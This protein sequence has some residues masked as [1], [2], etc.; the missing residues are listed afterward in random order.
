MI[1]KFDLNDDQLH[2]L[3][4]YADNTRDKLII[5]E[6]YKMYPSTLIIET[7]NC[8][9]QLFRRLESISDENKCSELQYIEENY[10]VLTEYVNETT[11]NIISD[12]FMDVDFDMVESNL[13]TFDNLN[14]VCVTPFNYLELKGKVP[15]LDYRVLCQILVAD[16]KKLK[17]SDIHITCGYKNMEP[18][19]WVD[20][21][22]DNRIVQANTIPFDSDR[23]KNLIFCIVSK[24]TNSN[25]N[26]I[27]VSGLS[28]RVEDPLDNHKYILRL[29]TERT[30]C[31]Y[32]CVIRIQD[33]KT[34]SLEIDQLGFDLPS[35]QTLKYLTN[36]SSG[37][38]LITGPIRS[39]KNT[40]AFAL[41]N[42]Y[43]RQ[44]LRLIDYSSPVET[45]MDF[46][47]IDYNDDIERLV[48]CIKNCK[49][50][51]TDI[52]FIN[53]IPS[54][55]VAFA[56]RDLVNSSVGVITTM[57]VERIWHLPNK[58]HDYYG[59]GYKDLIGQINAICNQKML[60]KQCSKC[61]EISS[62]K[63]LEKPLA[64]ML[65][66]YGVETYYTNKGC[67]ECING[68]IPGAVQPYVEILRFTE[69]IKQDLLKCAHPYEM[70]TYLY[71]L[72]QREKLSLEYKL[73]DAVRLGKIVPESLYTII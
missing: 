60:V 10:D 63:N 36:K 50:Q 73:T 31:G 4:R 15:P 46:S 14:Y 26:D 17:G 38:T 20:Y 52:A 53:E 28:T 61:Q 66:F 29:T 16:C 27:E 11:V 47:Q 40:T 34:V 67:D 32:H 58:L 21:R 2:I 54:S 30:I 48:S 44:P 68:S 22:I 18:S 6:Q 56:V 9:G 25:H 64:D 7:L 5:M 70:V 39:G 51:D 65:T 13:F 3:N 8:D 59:E 23:N 35:T 72:V 62:I 55:D 49:K 19:Y 41:A 71:E 45:L 33:M 1:N 69:K 43:L 57:H 37:L 42:S 12:P 24:L